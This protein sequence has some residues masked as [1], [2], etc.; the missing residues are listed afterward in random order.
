MRR[1]ATARPEPRGRAG[2]PLRE[3]KPEKY[4]QGNGAA[5][6][7]LSLSKIRPV[8]LLTLACDLLDFFIANDIDAALEVCVVLD[9]DAR[10]LDVADQTAF[11]TNRDL[12]CRFHVPLDLTLN[13]YL[14]SLHI[15]LGF[16][17]RTHCAA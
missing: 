14:P 6:V 1:I 17:I 16:A 11:F 9:Y 12:L 15:G 7:Q 4:T 2:R 8:W 3:A 5:S 10:G 13:D